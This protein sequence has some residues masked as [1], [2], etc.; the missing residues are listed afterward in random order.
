MVAILLLFDTFLLDDPLNVLVSSTVNVKVKPLDFVLLSEP[1]YLLSLL[2]IGEGFTRKS[3][4]D[5]AT[6]V[7][8][9]GNF[10]PSLP[11]P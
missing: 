9:S 5:V 3:D 2:R 11:K 6:V 1:E 10:S 7:A 8:K 4:S